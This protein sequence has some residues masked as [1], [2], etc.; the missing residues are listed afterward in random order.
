[1]MRTSTDEYRTRHASS[2][3]LKFPRIPQA[4]NLRRAGAVGTSVSVDRSVYTGSM[5]V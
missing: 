3:S 5:T 2:G 1:V 4:Q